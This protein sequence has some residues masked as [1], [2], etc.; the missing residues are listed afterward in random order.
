[1]HVPAT[2]GDAG[3]LRCD[4]PPLARSPRPSQSHLPG[5]DAGRDARGDGGGA[6]E[7]G[8]VLDL[9]LDLER[10]SARTV[11]VSASSDGGARHGLAQPFTYYDVGAPPTIDAVAPRLLPLGADATLTLTGGNFAPTGD[12]LQCRFGNPAGG[13]DVGGAEA[14]YTGGSNPLPLSLTQTLTQTLTLALP[15]ALPLT[16][17]R[18]ATRGGSLP[19]AL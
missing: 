8:G 6:G 19:P 4:A 11:A 17:T 16:L 5:G 7:A 18:P 14:G 13:T 9:D 15:L 3:T 12:R 2:F 10:P 1:M